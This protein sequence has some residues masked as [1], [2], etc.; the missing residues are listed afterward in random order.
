MKK[1]PTF[2][3]ITQARMSSTR[4][5]GKVALPLC[6]STVLGIHLQRILQSTYID[7]V[8][9]ASTREENSQQIASIAKQYSSPIV[10]GDVNDVLGRFQLVAE[11]YESDFYL[12]FTSDCPL[13]DAR[14]VDQLID[15]FLKSGADYGS[16]TINPTYPDGMDVEIFSRQ[17]LLRTSELATQNYDREHVTSFMRDSGLFK[18]YSLE[19]SIDLSKY[20]LTLDTAEDFEVLEQLIKKCG[21]DKT[22]LDY[23]HFLE[24]NPDILKI[25]SKFE[26]NFN[27][28]RG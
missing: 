5:P 8:V 13:I 4:L 16:N 12:R 28:I 25:N 10:Y 15:N 22:C 24:N 7:Q 18:L 20:R 21:D 3:A 14:I 6:H 1:L 2:T 26:R 9:V 27:A 17:A 23:I 11:S 19:N